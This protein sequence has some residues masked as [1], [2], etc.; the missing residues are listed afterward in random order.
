MRTCLR[1]KNAKYLSEGE[2]TDG[3]LCPEVRCHPAGTA[4]LWSQQVALLSQPHHMTRGRFCKQSIV[5]AERYLLQHNLGSRL[6]GR[7]MHSQPAAPR[8]R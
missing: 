6:F 4:L 2:C 5:A 3:S 8:P 7:P 1:C